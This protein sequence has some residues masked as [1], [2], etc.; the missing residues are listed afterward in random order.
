[1]K[2]I[3]LQ[4]TRQTLGERAY[5][6]IRDAIISLQFE[7]GQMIYENELAASLGVSRTPIREAFRMLLSEELIEILPQKGAKVTLISETKVEE[8][9]FV[10]E[11]L[12]AAAF[13][14]VARKWVQ[15]E[16]PYIS[17]GKQIDLLIDQ[18]ETAAQNDDAASFLQL[19]ET[20]H[21]HILEL[22][23]NQTLLTVVNHMRGHLNRL[24]YLT[25]RQLN[26][27]HELTD[28]HRRI[29]AAVQANDEQQASD[30]L[31]MHLSRLPGEMA[32]LK[33]QF[34]TYFS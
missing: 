19:D 15:D 8:T 20:F 27:M 24:R 12:E 9:R 25:L 32:S 22:S 29:W 13:Q 16:E 11:S 1:M 14:I 2:F 21:H 5:E 3:N 26:N 7:P 31:R 18:Q 28:Q 4:S 17:S 6:S 10:R 33:G 34:D 30:L 23:G